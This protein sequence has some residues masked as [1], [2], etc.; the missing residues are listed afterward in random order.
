MTA[1]DATISVTHRTVTTARTFDAVVDAIRTATGSLEDGFVKAVEG[2]ENFSAFE[3]TMREREG[4]SGFMRFLTI[5]HGAWMKRYYGLSCRAVTFVMGNPLVAITM[6]REDVEAGLNVPFRL[7]VIED[8]GSVR[9]IY[10]LPSTQMATLSAGARAAALQLD[11]KIALL[12]DA[13]VGDA[14]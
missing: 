14:A 10:D 11:A 6:L 13:V 4:S 12:V 3:A 5:D 7:M 1:M 2:V 9:L 8:E